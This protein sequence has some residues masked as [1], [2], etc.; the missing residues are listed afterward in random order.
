MTA[1]KDAENLTPAQKGAITRAENK[2]LKEEAAAKLLASEAK[3]A[4]LAPLPDLTPL[5]TQ[6]NIVNVTPTE[7]EVTR[8]PFSKAIEAQVN[9]VVG[10]VIEEINNAANSE[11]I[12]VTASK[13][14]PK[15]PAKAREIIYNIGIGLGAFAT[16]APPIIALLTGDAA[17]IGASAVGISLALT[18]L[19]SKLNLSKT[20]TDIAKETPA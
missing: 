3:E 5:P 15:I 10:K 6:V 18:N 11:Y 17:I 2:R 20:A 14:T 1:K 4:A 16:A 12:Q 9:P 7:V 19:L 8:D 13:V